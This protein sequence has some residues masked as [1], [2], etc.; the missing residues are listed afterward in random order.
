MIGTNFAVPYPNRHDKNPM[1]ILM[2]TAVE[3]WG[4][5]GAQYW[6]YKPAV[7]VLKKKYYNQEGS[8]RGMNGGSEL[9]IAF[10]TST[11]LHITG[12]ENMACFNILCRPF[13]ET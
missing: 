13:I 2:P 8:V 5:A 1:V 6:R 11:I 7:T 12:S 4:A 3:A 9:V 10:H